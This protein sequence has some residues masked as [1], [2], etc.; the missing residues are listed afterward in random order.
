ML[1]LVYV[2]VVVV[3]LCWQ[4]AE[5]KL[6]V[7]VMRELNFELDGSDELDF[8]EEESEAKKEEMRQFQQ[9][10]PVLIR[11]WQANQF[12]QWKDESKLNHEEG[13]KLKAARKKRG[14]RRN[15]ML[16]CVK[17]MANRGYDQFRESVKEKEETER[18]EEMD[19]Y[20][21]RL[22]DAVNQQHTL[23]HSMHS[24]YMNSKH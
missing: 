14:E 10:W 6:Q 7:A 11:T 24:R 2:C 1:V 13:G 12:R 5:R 16:E 17:F 9:A 22:N 19:R 8:D 21:Q 23:T 15:E 3:L 4:L 20:D 18:E